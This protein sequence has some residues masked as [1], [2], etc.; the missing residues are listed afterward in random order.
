MEEQKKERASL[1]KEALEHRQKLA[2]IT[3][4]L[5]EVDTAQS[6]ESQSRLKARLQELKK[7]E[8]EYRKKEEELAKKE[9]VSLPQSFVSSCMQSQGFSSGINS[10]VM[11]YSPHE[12]GLGWI[13]STCIFVAK[14]FCSL[15]SIYSTFP[16]AFS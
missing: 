12:K 15:V 7:Q 11:I 4:K 8:E 1:T 2:E 3:K 16:F 5:Q 6:K 14:H 13:F 9:R 10:I